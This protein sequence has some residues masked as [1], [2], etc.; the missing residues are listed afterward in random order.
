MFRVSDSD[1]ML[2]GKLGAG[3]LLASL[4]TYLM[5]V[6]ILRLKDRQDN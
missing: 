2:L 5:E 1:G 3:A 4:K 6:F